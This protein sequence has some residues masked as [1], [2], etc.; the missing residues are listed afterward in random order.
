MR[1]EGRHIMPRTVAFKDILE[2]ELFAIEN[3]ASDLVPYRKN[4]GAGYPY[5]CF[6][7]RD[8]GPTLYPARHAEAKEFPPSQ[9]V[10][11]LACKENG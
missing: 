8:G 9:M 7:R 5:E 3:D 11:R 10:Y 6:H 1:K 2:G 4:K